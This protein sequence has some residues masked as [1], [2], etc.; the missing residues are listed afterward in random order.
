MPKNQIQKQ[1]ILGTDL[2]SSILA[3]VCIFVSI[4]TGLIQS[5]DLVG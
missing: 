5:S 2:K 3:G 1:P 4:P